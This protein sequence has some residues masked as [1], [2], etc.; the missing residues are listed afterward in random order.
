MKVIWEA[1]N[2]VFRRQLESLPQVINRIIVGLIAAVEGYRYVDCFTVI[3]VVFV[4]HV[5]FFES[6]LKVARTEVASLNHSRLT[7]L[8]PSIVLKL[9]ICICIHQQQRDERVGDPLSAV[10]YAQH[11]RQV[12]AVRV[13]AVS[14]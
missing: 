8:F 12:R 5:K 14:G 6:W 4:S 10:P 7:N 1:G 11:S 2:D 9:F 3:S 13:R